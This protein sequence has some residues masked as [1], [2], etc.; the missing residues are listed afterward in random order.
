[1]GLASTGPLVSEYQHRGHPSQVI[2]CGGPRSPRC[3][4]GPIACCWVNQH[5]GGVPFWG[6]LPSEDKGVSCPEPVLARSRARQA[7]NGPVH[8]DARV[9]LRAHPR[10]VHHPQKVNPRNGHAATRERAGSQKAGALLIPR[11][12]KRQAKM[13]SRWW[14]RAPHSIPIPPG[15]FSQP[16]REDSAVSATR[17]GKRIIALRAPQQPQRDHNGRAPLRPAGATGPRAAPD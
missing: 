5:P 3:A 11:R 4:V 1:M 7:N 10:Y 14:P 15:A 12:N 16:S 9:H 6:A 2:R 8:G 17:G 13:A